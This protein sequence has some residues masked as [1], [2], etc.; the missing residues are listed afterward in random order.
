M[1]VVNISPFG[2]FMVNIVF[3]IVIMEWR[4]WPVDLCNDVRHSNQLMENF[5]SICCV[6]SWPENVRLTKFIFWTLRCISRFPLS[7]IWQKSVINWSSNL[8]PSG[9]WVNNDALFRHFQLLSMGKTEFF[10]SSWQRFKSTKFISLGNYL[11]RGISAQLSIRK[12][13]MLGST[14]WLV[15]IARTWDE[16]FRFECLCCYVIRALNG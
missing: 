7:K 4:V 8:K 2:F 12:P 14:A 11:S 16:I 3:L 10:W 6:P 5:T 9:P 15:H 13:F 1:L